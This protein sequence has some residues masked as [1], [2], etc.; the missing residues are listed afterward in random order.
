MQ[1]LRRVLKVLSIVLE[2]DWLAQLYKQLAPWWYWILLGLRVL[3]LLSIPSVLVQRRGR[4]VAAI[5]WILALVSVPP[6]GLFLW[7]LIGRRHL[8]RRRRRHSRAAA[9]INHRFKELQDQ[10]CLTPSCRAPSL[11]PMKNLPAE[12]AES[13]FRTTGGNQVRLFASGGQAFDCIERDIEAAQHHIHALFYIWKNDETGRRIRDLLAR[14]AREGVQVRVLCDAIGSP[15]MATRFARPLRRAGAQVARFLPPQWLSVTPRLNFRNHRKILVI[16]GQIGVIGGFNIGHEYRT[17][18]R[19]MGIRI[20]GP[21]VD[22]LQEV[23]AEDWYYVSEEDLADTTYFGKWQ[24]RRD[25]AREETATDGGGEA[26][27]AVIASGPDTRYSSIHDALF[28]AINRTRKRLL[29]TTPY[30]IPSRP[31]LAALRAALYRGVDVRIMVPGGRN[32]VAIVRH[33]SR[34]YYPELLEVG[35]Q[36][37]EYQPAMLH[38]KVLVFDDS[39]AMIGSANLDARSFR[40]NFEASCFVGGTHLPNALAEV[41]ERD[42]EACEEVTLDQLKDRSWPSKL[43]DATANLLSPLL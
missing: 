23:F 21:A 16:D 4:P 27:C 22:Q 13:V 5:S 31:I 20:R 10:L 26:A 32:D 3:G 15:V 9:T 2:M 35:A 24:E 18:W 19:D 17:R 30:F 37:L 40:L 7:W 39:L 14:K 34:S 43:V 6:L 42:T 38:A 8:E 11:L 1:P 29:I 25:E 36:I 28:M 33:A 41:F 12:L